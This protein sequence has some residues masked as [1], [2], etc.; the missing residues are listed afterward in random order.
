MFAVKLLPWKRLPRHMFSWRHSLLR[1]ER[2]RLPLEASLTA[3]STCTYLRD[4]V[5]PFHV[6]VVCH[7]A[8]K[9]ALEPPVVLRVDQ[10]VLEDALALVA[11]ETNQH[12]WR[13]HRLVAAHKHAWF[14]VCAQ[15]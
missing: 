4:D 15:P 10:P 6:E 7:D 1:R 13:R 3:V 11:P 12:F 14:V 5:V 8:L 9:E 2:Y